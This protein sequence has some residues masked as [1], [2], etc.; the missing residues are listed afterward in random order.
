M[1][2]FSGKDKSLTIAIL[3]LLT[4]GCTHSVQLTVKNQLPAVPPAP[5]LSISAVTKDKSGPVSY[6]HLDVYKRQALLRRLGRRGRVFY[7]AAPSSL[8][9]GGK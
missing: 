8:P 5:N 9:S 6:T 4:S 3:V 1:R 2:V 7:C